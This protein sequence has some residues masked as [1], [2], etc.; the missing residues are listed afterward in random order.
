M[1]RTLPSCLDID[2]I[3]IMKKF[4]DHEPKEV[5]LLPPSLNDWLPQN[6]PAYF[7]S[8]LVDGFD[9]SAPGRKP[10]VSLNVSLRE[11][12]PDKLVAGHPGP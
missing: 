8:D 4:R 9:L 1:Y 7:V 2:R 5:M 11:R 12:R 3:D 10:G 6:H